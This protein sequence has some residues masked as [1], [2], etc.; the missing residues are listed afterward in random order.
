MPKASVGMPIKF[1][2][3]FPLLFSSWNA[4]LAYSPGG[5]LSKI[6]VHIPFVI[7]P[8]TFL[9][10]LVGLSGKPSLLLNKKASI[11]PLLFGMPVTFIVKVFVSD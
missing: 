3:N 2:S 11:S 4:P 8:L 1:S 10:T 6:S 5:K 9:K 7:L